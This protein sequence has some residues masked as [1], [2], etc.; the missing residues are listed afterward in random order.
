MFTCTCGYMAKDAKIRVHCFVLGSLR[1]KLWWRMPGWTS[2]APIA[3]KHVVLRCQPRTNQEAKKCEEIEALMRLICIY[4]RC[5]IPFGTIAGEK[6]P[7]KKKLPESSR[8]GDGGG[9]EQVGA[10]WSHVN[11]HTTVQW[12]QHVHQY[13][14]LSIWGEIKPA[15]L[16]PAFWLAVDHQP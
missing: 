6:R 2:G 13:W 16:M 7:W 4:W 10:H 9:K 15:L 1:D 5:D 12:M 11:V 3:I 14:N 8:N